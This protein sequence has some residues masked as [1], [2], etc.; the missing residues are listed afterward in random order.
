M[1]TP[2]IYLDA[3]YDESTDTAVFN[4]P[5]SRLNTM[6]WD[7]DFEDYP[8]ELLFY[9]LNLVGEASYVHI[10][11]KDHESEYWESDDLQEEYED[12][13]DYI[14]AKLPTDKKYFRLVVTHPEGVSGDFA[15]FIYEGEWKG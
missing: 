13:S 2:T 4:C 6:E 5:F 12:L 7:Y 3:E 15:T 11:L 1:S 14:L 8:K 10:A 9:C